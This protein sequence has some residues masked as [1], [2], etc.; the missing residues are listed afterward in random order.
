MIV[1]LLGPPECGKST[2]ADLI[3][4]RLGLPTVDV[5]E[6]L[7]RAA[8]EVR[9]IIAAVSFDVG[10][11][12]VQQGLRRVQPQVPERPARSPHD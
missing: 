3:F 7:A 5:S 6:L 8:E 10:S 1:L 2:Q 9:I 11:L 4:S 12:A